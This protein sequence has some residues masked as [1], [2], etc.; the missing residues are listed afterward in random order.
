MPLCKICQTSYKPF[1]N[2]GRM[3]IANGFLMP[4]QFKD[5]YFFD[6]EIGA[7]PDC[8]TVQL[9]NQPDRERMF[10]QNYAFFSSTSRHMQQHFKEFSQYLKSTFAG[11]QNPFVVEMG[12][13]DGIMLQNF[14]QEKI[15]HLGI[16]PSANVAQVARQKG[17]NTIVEF[18]DEQ[19]ADKVSSSEGQADVF[20][21]ANVMCHIPYIHSI[22]KGIKKI[23]KPKGV[24]A[25]EDPYWGDI[26][27]KT[28]YDQIYDEHVFFFSATSVSNIFRQHDLELF[29]VLPQNV[30]GGSMRYVLGHKGQHRIS[31]NVINLLATEKKLGFMQASSYERFSKNVEKSRQDLVQLLHKLKAERKKVIGYAATSKSTTIL[32]L[33]KID[34]G[35]IEYITDTTPIKQG[36]FSPGMHIPI[37][38]YERFKNPY[39][40]YAFLFAWNHEKEIMEKE[41]EYTQKHGKWITYVPHVHII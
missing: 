1:F 14:A 35:L 11:V 19:V 6:M 13:N 16:E 29:D 9:V 32:N 27:E 22:A 26:L 2:F 20:S 39:P 30:H 8:G 23:L 4:E 31:N 40:D 38:P 15:R 18:F 41:T 12:S 3:P 7:C 28:S 10:N 17:I 21:C 33:C 37:V 24:L 34:S 25:F 36:K 5:E